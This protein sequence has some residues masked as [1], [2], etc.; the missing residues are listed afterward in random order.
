MLNRLYFDLNHITARDKR[1]IFKKIQEERDKVGYYSLPQQSIDELVEFEESL[2]KDID[3]IVVIGIGG[4]SLG[5]RAVYEFIKPTKSLK[6]NL[7]FFESTDPI[8]IKATLSKLNLDRSLVVVVSKSGTTVETI[9]LFKYFFSLMGDIDRYIFITDEGSKLANFADSIGAKSFF[10]PKNVG[11][12]F[13]V[14]SSASLLPLILSGVEVSS[15]LQGA[16]KIMVSFFE[17]GY[18]KDALL[19]KAIF[20]AKNHNHFNINVIFAYSETMEFFTRWYI[21][22]WGESLGKRQE[23]SLFNVGVTPIG[24][25]GP[26]DQHSFLQLLMHGNRDKTITFIKI[27]NLEDSLK[28]PEITLPYLEELDIINGINFNSLINLQCDATKEALLR[29]KEIPIDE[30]IL[31][32][33][34]EDGIGQL[35]YYYELLTSLVGKLIN[36]NTYNQPAVDTGKSIL[37]EKLKDI[38]FSKK[39]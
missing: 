30:I 17:D 6:R 31:E 9:A 18:I 25:I 10:I 34:D 1:W 23:C 12:R 7:L 20:Y 35:I 21:Q 5:T 16:K 13:S 28:I 4:S 11:G 27:D 3:N 14:L 38:K 33:A 22:L 15:L 24:L 39:G 32:R 26:K 8:N 36:V 19:S 29:E 37:K 2:P